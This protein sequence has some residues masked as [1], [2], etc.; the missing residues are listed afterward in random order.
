MGESTMVANVAGRRKPDLPRVAIPCR[1]TTG[2]M[3]TT[4][5]GNRPRAAVTSGGEGAGGTGGAA[6]ERGRWLYTNRRSRHT[7]CRGRRRAW[8]RRGRGRAWR[9]VQ[10]QHRELQVRD[11]GGRSRCDI[12]RSNRSGCDIGRSN[13]SERG[14]GRGVVGTCRGGTDREDRSLNL[15]Q[16]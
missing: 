13:R 3:G 14:A 9:G 2:A 4:P 7:C 11:I 6:A 5:C 15:R 10:G 8:W 1:L 12:G 16:K